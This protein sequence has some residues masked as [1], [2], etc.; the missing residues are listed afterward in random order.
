VDT[1][2]WPPSSWR[3]IA[4]AVVATACARSA[5]S[6]VTAQ[7]AGG[8][9]GIH[10]MVVLGRS[11]HYFEHIPMFR[12]PHDEQLV[13]RVELRDAA[14]APIDA[15]FGSATFTFEPA[16]PSSL[17]DLAR[18][19]AALTG[20]IHRGSFERGGEVA[21]AG[22][23]ATVAAVVLARPLPGKPEVGAYEFGAADDVYVTNA[24][25]PD[26]PVQH[27]LH[28]IGATEHGVRDAAQPR[29]VAGGRLAPGAML[30]G[31]ETLGAELWCVVGPDFSDP[32]P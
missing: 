13:L 32:C 9:V 31:G 8:R 24:I 1:H 12:P 11:V 16:R 22:V 2:T 7:P 30:G 15:D 25:S 29:F 27:I 17:D 18:V 21:I 10:G 3:A 5:P 19:G 26:R 23:T 6:P 14:G 28:V 20:D 4:F